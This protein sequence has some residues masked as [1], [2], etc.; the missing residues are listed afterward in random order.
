MPGIL[1]HRLLRLRLDRNSLAQ[2]I[3]TSGA[4]AEPRG[5]AI[6]HGNILANLEPLE[7]AIQPYLKWERFVHP[8]RFL[9]LVP[10]SHVFGQF[11][12]IWVPPLLGAAVVFQDSL[13]PSEIISTIKRE[14]ISVLI[15]VPRVLEALQNKMERDLEVTDQLAKFRRNFDAAAHEKFLRR[16]WRFRRIHRQFGWK[17]WAVISGGATL[18][19]GTELFWG[20]IGIAAIQ[21]Y[22]LTET[23]SLVSVN[24]PF[25]LGRGSIGKVLQ[26]RQVKLDENGEI[27]VRGE[28]V[29]D[30]VLAGWRRASDDTRRGR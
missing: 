11:M 9:D 10:L 22:G 13:N 16:M 29:A 17:F 21:G 6:S 27:L 7:S 19:P 25:Q 18:D 2:I 1:L 24:H 8:L 4:T 20:R 12:G 23:T 30:G 3:F 28:N 15:T 26:G 14:R 5:V